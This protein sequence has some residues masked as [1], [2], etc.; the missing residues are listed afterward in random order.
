[1]KNH[2]QKK[3]VEEEDIVEKL[4]NLQV[5]NLEEHVKELDGKIEERLGLSNRVL[6]SLGNKA[7]TFQN[8]IKQLRY[9]VFPD[10]AQNLIS[11]FEVELAK[12]GV[13]KN[14]EWLDCFRDVS[15]LREKLQELTKELKK[16]RLK[17]KLLE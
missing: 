13:Q 11:H 14:K 6:N 10:R 15:M 17:L 3:E 8:N 4:F 12:I 5:K 16:E 9:N 2:D 1:M 7:L